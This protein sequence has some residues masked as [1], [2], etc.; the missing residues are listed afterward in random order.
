MYCIVW[1]KLIDWLIVICEICA[2]KLNEIRRNI[3]V[4]N[5]NNNNNN[6]MYPD[7]VQDPDPYSSNKRDTTL[8]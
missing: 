3:N 2:L 4:I 8:I 1:N 7:S 6:T 5:N